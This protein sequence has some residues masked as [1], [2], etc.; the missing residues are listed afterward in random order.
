MNESE[1]HKELCQRAWDY[2]EMH[3]AQRLTTF[4]FYV[5]L[6]SVIATSLFTI[7]PSS[8]ASRVGWLLGLL[9]IFFSFVFWKLDSRNKGLIKGAEAAIKYFERN[10]D[11]KDD[12]GEPHVA[13][14]FL[15]EEFMTSKR[16]RKKSI[17]F[18]RNY[19][20]YSN[21]FNIIFIGFGLAGLA[22]VVLSLL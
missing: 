21:C 12:G 18:W 1:A 15:R 11:L 8:Q 4:N 14:I 16:R 22:G 6:S 7:L 3:A 9:L 13:K 19:L 5:V 20:S 17:F 2:F 10:S